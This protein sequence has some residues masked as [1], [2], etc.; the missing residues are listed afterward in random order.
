MS[1]IILDV[2]SGDDNSPST[3]LALRSLD[4]SYKDG[5]LKGREDYFIGGDLG[6][7]LYISAGDGEI[8]VE[9]RDISFTYLYA[10]G[11]KHYYGTGLRDGLVSEV[12]DDLGSSL[13]LLYRGTVVESDRSDLD[14]GLGLVGLGFWW[15]RND[16]E[17]SR[18]YW[19]GSSWSLLM[20]TE[21]ESIGVVGD[22]LGVVGLEGRLIL[23]GESYEIGG[24]EIPLISDGGEIPE[25]VEGVVYTPSGELAFVGHLGEEVIY[26]RQE[27]LEEKGS[28]V[29]RGSYLSPC[30]SVIETPLLR[31]GDRGYMEVI[32]VLDFSEEIERGVVELLE[33]GRIS[34]G[35]IESEG[36]SY[37]GLVLGHSGLDLV[38]YDL[39]QV[40]GSVDIPL[41]FVPDGSGVEPSGVEPSGFESDGSRLILSYSEKRYWVGIG[42]NLLECL[43]VKDLPKVLDRNV[44]Y[45]LGSR[46]YLASSWSKLVSTEGHKLYGGRVGCLGGVY[47]SQLSE[48][49]WLVESGSF[50]LTNGDV[51][52]F[53]RSGVV[54]SDGVDFIG[55]HILINEGYEVSYPSTESE[56]LLLKGLGLM[57][58]GHNGLYLNLLGS[59]VKGYER[60]DSESIGVVNDVSTQ[61]FLN[62]RPRQDLGGYSDGGYYKAGENKLIEGED[63]RV[64]SL[65]FDWIGSG[66]LRG[67]VREP[68]S[69]INLDYGVVEGSTSLKVKSDFGDA[70]FTEDTFTEGVDYDIR[71]GVLRLKK[72]LGSEV[73]RGY[74]LTNLGSGLYSLL[75]DSSLI[76]V[77][78]FISWGSFYVKVESVMGGGQFTLSSSDLVSGEGIWSCLRGYREGLVEGETPDLTRLSGE[79]LKSYS[80]SDDVEVYKVY[81]T[82]RLDEVRDF[83]SKLLIRS[84]EQDCPLV[85]LR[86]ENVEKTPYY[87]YDVEDVHILS[88]S[89][90][91][92]VDGVDYREGVSVDNLRFIT[93]S[94][95]FVFQEWDG[96]SWFESDWV[97]SDVILIREPRQNL[98]DI[99][100]VSLSGD[101][102][103]SPFVSLDSFLVQTLGVS[104][105]PTSG[106][107][108]FKEPLDSGIGIEVLYTSLDGE[109]LIET[110]VF[111]VSGEEATRQS[112]KRYTFNSEGR[113]VEFDLTPSIYIDSRKLRSFEYTF[114]GSQI[115]FREP[116]DLESKVKVSYGV[117]SSIGGE[118]AVRLS[119]SILSSKFKIDQGTNTILTPVDLTGEIESGDLIKVGLE[120]FEVSSVS[121][122]EITTTLPCRSN[123]EAGKLY[124]FTVP[125]LTYD[126]VDRQNAF[127]SLVGCELRSKPKSPE[128]TIKGDF[129]SYFKPQTL[130]RVEGVLYEVLQSTLTEDG[131]TLITIQGF[132]F[133][134]SFTSDASSLIVSYRPILEEGE[135]NLPVSTGVISEYP[136]VLI[137]YDHVKGY[138]YELSEGKDYKI[139]L[140]TGLVILV[141][142]GVS[143]STSYYFLHTALTSLN[144]IYLAGGRAS[145]PS[146]EVSYKASK[147][148]SEYKGLN[149]ETSCFV[150][151]PDTFN[152]RVVDEDIYAGEVAGNLIKR[153]QSSNGNGAKRTLNGAVTYGSSLSFYDILA[154]DVVA[155]SR[156]LLYDGY[157]SPLE[158]IMST[159]TGD[160][161]GDRDGRFKF[162][163]MKAGH[164][165][166]AGLE[167][168]LTR[169]IQPRYVL[170]ELLYPLN[171]D[172]YPSAF[173][174]I[175]VDDKTPD[176]S[177]LKSLMEDQKKL[178]MNEMDDYVM[179]SWTRSLET[180]ITLPYPH[181]RYGHLPQYQQSY[182]P[183]IFSRLFPSETEIQTVTVPGDLYSDRD[184]KT[185][186]GSVIAFA[187]NLSLGQIT[188]LSSL[189][190]KKRPSRFRVISYSAYGFPEID[191]QSKG[192]PT[193]LVSAVSL[194]DFPYLNGLP[195][196]ARFI[197]EGGSVPDI[198]TGNPDF[199][200]QGLSIGTHLSLSV[201]DFMQP[202]LDVSDISRLD[203][204]FGLDV[205]PKP[206]LAK[207]SKLLSGCLVVLD[208]NSG[209]LEV[210][211][212]S[213]SD[214]EIVLGDTLSENIDK[215][216]DSEE[217]L[218]VYRVGSDVGLKYNTG[219]IID[220]SLP[221]FEDPS[222]P[223]QE[224][225]SQNVPKGLTALEGKAS[226]VY[227]SVDPFIY[228]ALQGLPV[229]D[230]G[231]YSLPYLKTLS[232]RDVLAE[233]QK[234]IPRVLLEASNNGVLESVYPDDLRDNSALIASGYLTTSEDFSVVSGDALQSPRQGDLILIKPESLGAGSSATGIS[235]LALV[236]GTDLLM[237]HFQSPTD[238]NSFSLT[239]VSVELASDLDRGVTVRERLIY[240]N[241]I[242][243][244][245]SSITDILFAGYDNIDSILDKITTDGGTLTIKIHDYYGPD[246]VF[247]I[248]LTYDAGWFIK[249]VNNDGVE[250]FAQNISVTGYTANSIE[251]TQSQIPNILTVAEEVNWPSNA[252]W[253]TWLY[254][255]VALSHFWGAVIAYRF[256]TRQGSERVAE[257]GLGN[258]YP[259]I[260]LDYRLDVEFGLSNSDYIDSNRLDFISDFDFNSL[261]SNTN[262]QTLLDAGGGQTSL[263][264]TSVFEI[265]SSGVFVKEESGG[266][267]TLIESDINTNTKMGYDPYLFD[268][269][270]IEVLN[271]NTLRFKSLHNISRSDLP[272][273]LFVGSEVQESG[274]ILSGTARYGK[275]TSVL[276]PFSSFRGFIR[277]ISEDLGSLENVQIGDLIYLDKGHASGTHRISSVE[278]ADNSST[279]AESL[280]NSSI[281][282]AVFP[283]IT[284]VSYDSGVATVETDMEDLSLHFNDAGYREITILLND[285]YLVA[286]SSEV[287]GAYDQTF[288]T[289]ALR[290]EYDSLD[291][292][293]FLVSSDPE[294]LDGQSLLL[295][296]L[297]ALLDS[298]GQT[299]AGIHKFK[300]DTLKT[301]LVS[302]LHIVDVE[303]SFDYSLQ[304]AGG[305]TGTSSSLSSIYDGFIVS[306]LYTLR[307]LFG[308]S[309][310]AS[311]AS[312]LDGAG[313]DYG[314]GFITPED[315]ITFTVNSYR[316][317]YLDNSFPELWR[318]Y[319]GTE[320]VLL[321]DPTSQVKTF[322]D[323]TVS[324]TTGWVG[325]EEV[326]FV[327]RRL[328][329]FSEL[330]TRLHT[331]LTGF[332]FLYDERYGIVSQIDRV[333]DLIRL[334]SVEDYFDY[335]GQGTNI[336]LFTDTVSIGDIVRCFDEEDNET[337][338]FRVSEVDDT[339]LLGKVVS[340]S[341]SDLHSYFKVEVRDSLVPEI[342]SFEKFISHGF[343]EVYSSEPVDGISVDQVNELTDT[344]VDFNLLL[345][346][347]DQEL[348]YLIIDPQGLL[349]NTLDEYG[350]PPLGDDSQGVFGSPSPLDDNRGVYKITSFTANSISVEFYAG[351]DNPEDYFLPLVNGVSS[352]ELRVTAGIENGTYTANP[353]SIHPFSYKIYKRKTYLND[354][355]AALV[356]FFRERTL[357]W[358]DKIRQFNSIPLERQTWALYEAEDLIDKV[359]VNDNTHPSN[360][361]LISTI[362]GD[363]SFPF[364][365]DMLSVPDR[366]LLVEDPQML[367]EGHT[368]VTGMPSLFNSG[369]SIMEAREKRNRWIKVRT[370]TVEGTL[371]KLSRIDLASPDIKALEDIDE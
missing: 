324:G 113:D 312:I 70:G 239:N 252:A 108:S 125:V 171:S 173:D 366:R 267:F 118:Q 340:G 208:G 62:F 235:E 221:S 179:T 78:D 361:L 287:L 168:P 16:I 346:A 203:S 188:N 192:Q 335:S 119:G 367:N 34:Y 184:G 166:G 27:G 60:Y 332:R 106:S 321:G 291:G 273:S 79:V 138:G 155:R 313:N 112:D 228:P 72:D 181:L 356:F 39:G 147:L 100:E 369:L 167:D 365:D 299:I 83:K 327:V 342:Q 326:G 275:Y 292:S 74:S 67:S 371:Q 139:D 330:F 30:P 305:L 236:Q 205:P 234:L 331:T 347:D 160:V 137:K 11:E 114:T 248:V 51:C 151:A 22:D 115:T 183:S 68:L 217:N 157:V 223:F 170:Q 225:E 6:D 279:F 212:V 314:E 69:T 46:V 320:P 354:S 187:E 254:N 121:S 214:A 169:E 5:L 122:S 29:S 210:A 19:S 261:H 8:G 316:G 298:A 80:A 95:R 120:W 165:G 185:T 178:I 241:S 21:G 218:N 213:L 158:D 295:S 140:E 92:R 196:T 127:I 364:S 201:G 110:L 343:E 59:T 18:Y 352:N 204:V 154:E 215:D 61:Q 152:I 286:P 143:E 191:L 246:S 142:L 282:G 269:G 337:L 85:V 117:K 88:D 96:V 175:K 199:V 26:L 319:R 303:G 32:R 55:G 86:E 231:D 194:D 317:I 33:D 130:M 348:Y 238:A 358:A 28:L 257:M 90:R 270:L 318:D 40:V 333:G 322:S 220:I 182:E 87:N 284:S 288:S 359:G 243:A 20:G 75:G 339:Y 197:S 277:E 84:G 301:S 310:S 94:G 281:L 57:P 304:V 263:K 328:R 230:A 73:A 206:R 209:T 323:Y 24:L 174:L 260:Y 1:K 293:S 306:G 283:T 156:V 111:Y 362:L 177:T 161:V 189:T 198:T 172:L 10:V 278:L 345:N 64:N 12:F 146:Y 132:S 149:L 353:N 105:N 148:P 180:D 136:Y 101:D 285:N 163:L 135:K 325:Y 357:S 31:D 128:F 145:Y 43:F 98:E 329:R 300:F 256:F 48:K 338:K 259:I 240:N 262:E 315:I 249:T 251:I 250:V 52:D 23:G 370:N 103:S 216:L 66:S 25:G 150:Y 294:Y 229:N 222:F 258:N 308:G 268:S 226:F 17:R 76:R 224:I 109:D 134:H 89:Y 116:L 186:N 176:V 164:W 202:I 44:G 341:L 302:S 82:L 368:L 102:L 200:F 227:N 245:D 360:D 50:S 53:T 211:G 15:T 289:S 58:G 97:T 129:V 77:G 133:G 242:S 47:G 253:E 14:V 190:L 42:S 153:V 265:L 35:A 107:I 244:W 271:L 349:P 307:V 344:N 141:G 274:E 71:Q 54:G 280:T 309:W 219:E 104:F 276:A 81:S 233:N 3:S 193:F 9:S 91:L 159:A 63:Y 266:G 264:V 296:S 207:V 41:D 124:K 45:I 363:G 123:T 297:P 355:L 144:P 195:D 237:P 232:E 311:F 13:R 290:L 255:S 36:L 93:S 7:I 99:A 2:R 49:N 4:N 37:D 351:D 38:G 350:Q 65:G 162:D 126:S 56:R 131:Y 334:A 336:G 247:Q 272:L